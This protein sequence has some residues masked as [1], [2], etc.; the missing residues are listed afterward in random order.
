MHH[1]VKK[2]PEARFLF[3]GDGEMRLAIE[4]NIYNLGLEKNVIL[5][6]FVEDIS[7]VYMAADIF[8]L[9]SHEEGLCT[10]IL[11]AMYFSLPLVSTNAGGIPE[12]IQDGVNGLIVPVGDYISLAEKLNI[13]IE[14][15]ERRKKMGARSLQILEQNKIENTIEKTLDVYVELLTNK[16]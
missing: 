12:L 13:L 9:S 6:G 10:S 5:L 1:V 7:T 8:A 14:N 2:H 11:D 15:P 3:A 4:K 16:N